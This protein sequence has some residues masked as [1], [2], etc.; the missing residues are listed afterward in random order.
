LDLSFNP[1]QTLN[2]SPF[3]GGRRR[4]RFQVAKTGNNAPISLLG[5][6]SNLFNRVGPNG[7]LLSALID[8]LR[9]TTSVGA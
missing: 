8:A 6:P 4:H 1:V 9:A 3:G 2:A 7:G 5:S